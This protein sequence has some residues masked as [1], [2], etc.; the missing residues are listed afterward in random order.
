MILTVNNLT[1]SPQNCILFSLYFPLPF[2]F[3][4]KVKCNTISTAVNEGTE[5]VVWFPACH[6]NPSIYYSSF[7]TTQE[8]CCLVRLE[9]PFS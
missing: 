5:Q 3:K 7:F 8:L 2:F 9:T 4:K 1:P 6:R